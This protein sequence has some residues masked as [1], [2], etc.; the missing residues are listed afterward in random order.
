MGEGQASV[1]AR[2][3]LCP[4]STSPTL[5]HE[6]PLLPP[7]RVTHGTRTLSALLHEQGG[8]LDGWK[9]SRRDRLG[10][11]Q[12]TATATGGSERR[13]RV[14][15]SKNSRRKAETDVIARGCFTWRGCGTEDSTV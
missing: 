12:I 4:P 14:S 6:L 3:S 7:D 10:G 15:R 9:A 13:P 2:T 1:E 11:M 8:G 5:S